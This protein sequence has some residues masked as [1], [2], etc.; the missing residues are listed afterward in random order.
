MRRTRK[1]FS[2]VANWLNKIG[3][4]DNTCLEMILHQK[5]RGH[6]A[7]QGSIL[8]SAEFVN[9]IEIEPIYC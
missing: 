2:F 5:T 4:R 8:G 3:T 7:A 9:S 1:S 6:P